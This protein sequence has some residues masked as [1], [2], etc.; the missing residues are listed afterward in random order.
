VN[1]RLDELQRRVTVR[2]DANPAELAK[3]SSVGNEPPFRV[4][5]LR[6]GK[7]YCWSGHEPNAM[8]LQYLTERAARPAT[9]K[10][11]KYP[12]LEEA[13][14]RTALTELGAGWELNDGGHIALVKLNSM[15]GRS[16]YSDAA[17][18]H[19]KGLKSVCE[20]DLGYS[21]ITDAGLASIADLTELRSLYLYGTKVTDDGLR[22]LRRLDKLETLVLASDQF[23]DA[24]LP[25]V[26]TLHSLKVLNLNGTRVTDA[27]LVHLH[28]LKNLTELMVGDTKVTAAEAQRLRQSLPNAKIYPF[29]ALRR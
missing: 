27:G 23:S 6:S 16:R 22:H 25:Y 13:R 1:W 28:G 17:M 24:A 26:A 5:Y 15:P 9:Y 11:P 2:F 12:V 14:A 8:I 20:L 3:A 4:V 21:D 29:S 7:R 10:Y 19:L 18:V